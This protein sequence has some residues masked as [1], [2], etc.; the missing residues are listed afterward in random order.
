MRKF[1]ALTLFATA[2]LG[3][4]MVFGG[5][6]QAMASSVK[7]VGKNGPISS[8]VTPYLKKGTVLVPLN[9]IGKLGLSNLNMSWDNTRKQVRISYRR[10]MITVKVNEKYGIIGDEGD[11]ISAACP[12]EKWKGYGSCKIRWRGVG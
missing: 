4:S 12:D 7:V 5:H 6:N 9:I 11:S 8:D 10:V 3:I 2:A 1:K